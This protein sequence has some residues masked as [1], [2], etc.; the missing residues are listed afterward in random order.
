[1]DAKLL[2]DRLVNEHR[3][4]VEAIEQGQQAAAPDTPDE[5]GA[6]V[7]S[8]VDTLR[9]QVLAEALLERQIVRRRKIEAALARFES[10]SYGLCCAC[11]DEI[12]AERLEADAASVFCN[13]CTADR[14]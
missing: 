8:R 6:A 1:M 13:D 4:T 11:E 3:E 5:S 10:G 9:G 7:V 12:E 14:Q 2:R